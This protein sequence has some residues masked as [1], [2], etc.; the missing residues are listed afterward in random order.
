MASLSANRITSVALGTDTTSYATGSVSPTASG[1][2]LAV[3]VSSAI[4]GTPVQPTASGT[5]A[6][7]GTWTARRSVTTTNRRLTL[8]TSTA[9]S[10][11]AGVLTVAFGAETQLGCVFELDEIQAAAEAPVQ[12]Q[13]NNGTGLTS[14]AFTSALSAFA[15]VWNGLFACVFISSATAQ[16]ITPGTQMMCLRGGTVTS[17]ADVGTIRTLF[18][19]RNRTDTTST[20]AS[21]NACVIGYEV[22]HDGTDVGGGGVSRIVGGGIAA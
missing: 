9:Q 1:L 14:I 17:Q 18:Y 19:P 21:N 22:D 6:F 8:L 20:F 7:S 3:W 5:N 16:D 2:A 12:Y 10:T 11:T 4:S 15:D 13:D